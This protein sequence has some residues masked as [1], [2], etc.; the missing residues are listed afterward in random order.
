MENFFLASNFRISSSIYF[1][2]DIRNSRRVKVFYYSS[3]FSLWECLCDFFF[4]LF[5]SFIMGREVSEFLDISFQFLSFCRFWTIFLK[6]ALKI[7]ANSWLLLSAT[8][9]NVVVSLR[10]FSLCRKLQYRKVIVFGSVK[11][12]LSEF[13]G[14]LS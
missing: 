3:R 4:F 2:F 14:P 8:V 13:F 12:R 10:G 5:L 6:N 9:F 11:N 7:P 1:V